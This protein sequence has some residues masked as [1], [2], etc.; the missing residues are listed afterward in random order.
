MTFRHAERGAAEGPTG[1]GRRGS[2][3]AAAEALGYTQPA[4]SRDVALLER[5][6]GTKLLER[7]STDIRLTDAGQLLVGHADAILARLRDAEED[8]EALLGLR[9]EQLRMSTLTSAASTIVPLAIAE[10]AG[11]CRRSSCQS[12]W[13]IPMACCRCCGRGR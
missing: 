13:W 6:T 8:L 7:R 9:A 11:G 12:R 2:F 1:G 5:E 10:P 4:I 3:S